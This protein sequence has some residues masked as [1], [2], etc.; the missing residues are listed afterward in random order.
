MKGIRKE[1]N[2]QGI[3]LV[4]LVITIIVLVI[5][6]AAVVI[7]GINVPSEAK[8]AVELS[9]KAT[10]QDAVTI[11]VMNEMIK[12]AESGT[13]KTVEEITQELNAMTAEQKA[14]L[15]GISS[16][17]MSRYIISEKGVVNPTDGS[18]VAS[19]GVNSPKLGSG[20]I[21]VY[22]DENGNEILP[23]SDEDFEYYFE[24]D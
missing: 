16:N 24:E 6:T 15:L 21:A 9:D 22:W 1:S 23:P 13:I 12:S 4:A 20:M 7:T 8:Q 14:G 19:K 2:K 10:V 5:L 17:V 3:S 11:Y 18:Y